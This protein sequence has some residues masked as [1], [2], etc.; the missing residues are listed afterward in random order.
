MRVPRSA[1]TGLLVVL[2][3]IASSGRGSPPD[4]TPVLQMGAAAAV[5]WPA[6]GGLLVAE[7]V[8]G[9]ASASDEYIE[10]TNAGPGP[11]DLA[12]HEIVY[13]SASGATVT[14][15]AAWSGSLVVESGRHVLIANSLGIF[16][17]VADATYSG[18]LAAMGGAIALRQVGG[19]TVDA[20]GWGDA[21]SA[22]V[23]GDAA[24]A[25]PAGSSIERR[26]GGPDGNTADTNDN[27][28]D[29]LVRAQPV[30]QPLA[31]P[32][33]PDP[34]PTPS[35]SPTPEPTPDPTPTPTP[36]PLPTPEPTLTPTPLP[37]PEP[38]PSPVPSSTPEP[39]PDP[40]PTPTPTPEPTPSPDPTPTLAPTP[41][42]EPT[43]TL[44]PVL[45]VAAARA[46]ADG[47]RVVV[48]GVL[49]APLGSLEDGRGGFLQDS[50]AGIALLLPAD[51]ASALA[52]GTAVR[53]SGTVDDRYGQRTI[54]LDG[55]PVARG[56]G[57]LPDPLPMATGAAAEALEGRLV[58]AEGAVTE[59]PTALAT[60][61]SLQIDDGSGPLRVI[62]SFAGASAPARGDAIRVTGPLGQRDTTGTGSGGYRLLVTSQE[63]IAI[64]PPPSPTPTP[65]PEPTPE[66]TPSP[67]PT[68]APTPNPTPT[69]APT[70]SPSPSPTPTPPPTPVPTTTPMTIAAA[71]SAGPDARVTVEGV[72]TAEAG[73]IGLPPQLAIQDPTGAIVLRLPDGAP[74]PARGAVVRA[75]GK[76]AD[77]YGQLEIRPNSA[78]DV[79]IAGFTTIPNPF[80]GTA[81]MFG[82]ETE[83]RLVVL[84]G[85]LDAA[86]AREAGGDL[87]LRLVDDA[88][89]A[90]RAR[91]TRATGIVPTAARTGARL[92]L[93][94]IVGQRASRK[95]AL[96][97]YRLWLRDPA[98]LV[99][100][101]APRPT[102]SPTPSAS[103]APSVAAVR[104][105][106]AVVRLG[107]GS[108][109]V[110]GVVTIPAALLDASGRRLI[111]Q[112]ASAAIEVL[113][114]VG[115]AAP[116]P[117]T[118]LLIDGEIGTAYGAPRIRATAVHVLGVV[119]IPAPRALR[120]EPGSADE[121]DLVRIT[122]RVVDL[123]RLGDRWRAEVRTSGG[124]IVVAGLAGAGIPAAAI[125]EGAGVTVVGVVRRPHPAATDRRF[126][127]VPRASGDVRVD[128]PARTV[129]G[130]PGGP[131]DGGATAP[132]PGALPGGLAPAS[133]APVDADLAT[134]PGRAGALVRVGGLVVAVDD[135]RLL[136]DDGTATGDIR[137]GG[138]AAA[139][140]PLL[141]PGD[142][143]SAVGK[144]TLAATG[145]IVQVDDAAGLVRLGDLGEALPLD[146]G[147][148]GAAADSAVGPASAQ[149]AAVDPAG[150]PAAAPGPDPGTAPGDGPLVAGVG[151]TLVA[152]GGWAFLAAL[153][154]RR[155][156]RRLAAR[157][158]ARLAGLAAPPPYAAA[159]SLYPVL[160]PPKG[161]Q[162]G[163]PGAATRE[164]A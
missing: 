164:P 13:V 142:A 20:V 90:F 39:T 101:A 145:P 1:V 43:P 110:D 143:V 35:P 40:T 148:S 91:A 77:P 26:P 163:V 21:T 32:P 71:R 97:G 78:D 73:R 136:V 7:I 45:P 49:T 138:D 123:R 94:G 5:G 139:L 144:V 81:A 116:R 151:L 57:A 16:A 63:A 28:A 134:L 46:S 2:L 75:T 29:W 33:V 113:L 22:F 47:T 56:P 30:A 152:S 15:K 92:R 38:T 27:A 52:P 79:S 99:I 137:L 115:Q 37:T 135:D 84:E 59:T 19:L 53:A 42:P 50:S 146:P 127:V 95:G 61:I 93:T 70:P 72:V 106:A 14:R 103:P 126:A 12:G 150:L 34:G 3:G 44:E 161:S 130:G 107:E 140:L 74:R 36:T 121:G 124:T 24:P 154:R 88:G 64:V 102:A 109:R 65:T 68:P 100:T 132:R 82:E 86:I 66:P 67:S 162:P 51:P 9:G 141:E 119:A 83:A 58:A 118:R 80:P 128:D 18:G 69:P 54:R 55:S 62:L 133:D 85:T 17:A 158:S 11:L 157:I 10:V 41:T 87:V 8:T 117:G 25:P 89:V 125:P 98:D 153:R 156:R 96:D 31:A 122:G 111:V 131:G 155:D 23:E 108:V 105:I 160:A 120:G 104:S 6:S 76:L 114:P 48:E 4:P 149:S 159:T 129:A 147:G 112:D 60:G